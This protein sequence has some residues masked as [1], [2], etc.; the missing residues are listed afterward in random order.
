MLA[1]P[2][3]APSPE[4]PERAASIRARSSGS[5]DFPELLIRRIS[6]SPSLTAERRISPP[7]A[8]GGDG[9]AAPSGD[10][11][12]AWADIWAGPGIPGLVRVRWGAT[13]AEIAPVCAL[14]SPDAEGA[15]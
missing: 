8:D 13:E 14:P 2:R 5:M 9:S 3:C 7:P 4:S 6:A 1:R 11:E 15:P 12:P 10:R